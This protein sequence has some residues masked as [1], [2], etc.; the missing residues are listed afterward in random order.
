MSPNSVAHRYPFA[1][2]IAI[3]VASSFVPRDALAEPTATERALAQTLF[4]EARAEL[5]A[6]RYAAACP[7]LAESQRLDP[8]GGTLLN[9]AL[10]HEKT[11]HL[12]KAWAEYVDGLA[13]ARREG[14]SDRIEFAETHA[15]ALDRQLP[16]VRVNVSPPA[17]MTEGLEVHI[18]DTPIDRAAWG[19]W[20][21]LDPGSHSLRAAAKGMRPWA[22]T[23]TLREAQRETI[24]IPPLEIALPSQDAAAS[25]RA[26]APSAAPSD[27]PAS[28]NGES[29]VLPWTLVGVGGAAVVTGAVF[30]VMALDA[31]KRSDDLC[32]TDPCANPE[33]TR[34]SER[35]V[36]D[37]WIANVSIG[38][39][40]VTAG[41]G[42]YL[43]LRSPSSS[44]PPRASLRGIVVRF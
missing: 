21:P 28:P 2:A 20:V 30:G 17:S 13:Q 11:R 38:V 31:N 25:S 40:L 39:G 7:K 1:L 34:L 10:C 19:V 26:A 35:A 4:V 8:G 14:R 32:P 18:D 16:R 6:G 12:A 29:R 3:G 37:A 33:A 44:A 5:E 22:Q 42:V 36:R 15:A 27:T 24:E 23:V 41:V 9:L 43:L